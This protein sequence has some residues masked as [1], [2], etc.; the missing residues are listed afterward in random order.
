[1]VSKKGSKDKK[2]SEAGTSKKTTSPT[3]NTRKVVEHAK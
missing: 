3:T 2:E 1:M